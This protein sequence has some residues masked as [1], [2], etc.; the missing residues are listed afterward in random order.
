MSWIERDLEP[1]DYQAFTRFFTELATGDPVPDPARYEREVRPRGFFLEVAGAP[2]AYGVCFAL[3]DLGYVMHVV[4]APE[5]RGEG[6]GAAVMRVMARRLRALGVRRWCLN[7][8][9]DNEPALR[10]YRSFGLSTAYESASIM[11]PWDRVPRLPRDAAP[12]V[13]RPLD[14]ADDA[15]LEA[16]FALPAG[17]I[18]EQRGRGRVL[19]RLEDPAAPGARVGLASFDPSF[20]GAFPFAV[21]RP[22]LALPLLEALRPH[23]RP[24][25]DHVRLMI[26]GDAALTQVLCD[27]GA[28]VHMRTLHLRGDVPPDA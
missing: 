4:V 25:D 17:R 19:V 7:V 11:L 8:K 15:S 5:R 16:A 26:E 18:A 23:A 20:P 28:V 14:P 9:P 3:A 1:A 6:L 2:A 21:A 22:G 12:V 24:A 10:L 27:A 13:A